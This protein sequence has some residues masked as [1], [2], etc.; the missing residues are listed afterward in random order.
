MPNR[1]LWCELPLPVLPAALPVW[2]PLAKPR[3]GRRLGHGHAGCLERGWRQE[4][5]NSWGEGQAEVCPST[6]V[7]ELTSSWKLVPWGLGREHDTEA[8][9]V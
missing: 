6:G 2:E 7:G 3:A 1:A 5:R 8:D 4:D 9:L